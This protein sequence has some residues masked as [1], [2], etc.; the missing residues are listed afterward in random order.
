MTVQCHEITNGGVTTWRW[1]CE[2]HRTKGR[3]AAT[4]AVKEGMRL[5]DGS[6][7]DD[8]THAEQSAPGYQTPTVDYAPTSPE[9]QLPPPGFAANQPGSRRTESWAR[10]LARLR[11]DKK[12]RA[13]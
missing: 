9:S 13:A 10:R 8:C 1:L 4:F 5:P 12:R 7:C 2:A 6:P 11:I 3:T